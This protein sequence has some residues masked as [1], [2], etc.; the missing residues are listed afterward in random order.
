MTMQTSVML[1][2]ESEKLSPLTTGRDIIHKLF[3]RLLQVFTI[4]LMLK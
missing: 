4:E 1:G 3:I 2:R